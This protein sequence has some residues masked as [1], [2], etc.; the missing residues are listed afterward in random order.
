LADILIE[1]DLGAFSSSDFKK[2]DE[3]VKAGYRAAEKKI[4]EILQLLEKR[5]RRTKPKNLLT[6]FWD[7][8]LTS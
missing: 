4:P 8:L 2:A 3:L 5:S 1:P 6:R 7:W